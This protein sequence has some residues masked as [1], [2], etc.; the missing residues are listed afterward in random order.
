[1]AAKRKPVSA[2]VRIRALKRDR[3]ACTYCGVAG[4][5]AELEI[6]HIVPAA[7]GGSN[8]VSNLTTACR[9]CNQAKGAKS[10]FEADHPRRSAQ[11]FLLVFSPTQDGGR[12]LEYQAR[13]VKDEGES[14]LVETFSFLTGDPDRVMLLSRDLVFSPMCDLYMDEE[15]WRDRCS[16]ELRDARERRRAARD[17][18]GA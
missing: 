17:V 13:M 14:M 7:Q 12:K 1:M 18:S 16:D 3:Y 2:A 9:R 15:V 6:D 10:T 5:D 4:T 11:S 8:H